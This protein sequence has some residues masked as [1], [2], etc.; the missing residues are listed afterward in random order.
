MVETS[1][2]RHGYVLRDLLVSSDA[3]VEARQRVSGASR[4]L[5]TCNRIQPLKSRRKCGASIN[6]RPARAIAGHTADAAFDPSARAPASEV[7]CDELIAHC[8]QRLAAYKVP[9]A[10]QFTTALPMTPSGKIMRRLLTDIDD[11]TRTT[12]SH[13][14]HA[15]T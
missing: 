9:R 10:I 4:R 5:S 15:A 13:L 11:G 2:V 8:R 6:D 12:A 1:Y 7:T 14:S 3:P